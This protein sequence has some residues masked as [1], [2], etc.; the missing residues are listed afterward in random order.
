MKEIIL[1]DYQEEMKRR[2]E[3]AFVSH[4]S[5]M[6]Q[7][8]TGTGKTFLLASVVE[9]FLRNN[10]KASVWIV[11]HRRELVSQ[12]E[13]TL[14][15]FAPSFQDSRNS[16]S[17]RNSRN[18]AS[19]SSLPVKVCSIQWLTRHLEEMEGVGNAPGLIVIDEAHHAL[20]KTYKVLWERCPQAK[21]LGLTATPCRLNGRGFTDLFEVLVQSW[22]IPRFISEGRLATYDFVSIKASSKTQKLIDSLS[23]RGADGDYQT[24]EMDR[25]LNKRPSIERLFQSFS[26]YGKDRKGIVYAIDIDHAKAIA[27]FYRE[28]GISAVA[29]DSKTPCGLRKELIERFKLSSKTSSSNASSGFF[30]TTQSL[31]HKEG[32]TFSPSPSSSGSGD[33]TAPFNSLYDPFGSPCRGQKRRSEPLRSKVGGPSEVSPDFLTQQSCDCLCGVN[34]LACKEGRQDVQNIQV[35]VNVDIFSEGFD[36]PDV[37]FVQLARP[38]LSLAKYLQMVGRGLRVAHGKRNCV[39][40]DNVGLYRV[41]G[42]PSQVWNWEAMFA[43]RMSKRQLRETVS[44]TLLNAAVD[45]KDEAL[46]DVDDEMMM[47]VT[48]EQLAQTFEL[49][50]EDEWLRRKREKVLSGGMGIVNFIGKDL[51]KLTEKNNDRIAYVDLMNLNYIEGKNISQPKVVTEGGV[52]FLKYGRRLHSRTRRVITLDSIIDKGFYSYSVPDKHRCHCKAFKTGKS[53]WGGLAVVFLHD[54]PMDFYWLS[55]E[56]MDASIV[57]MGENGMYYWVENGKRKVCIGSGLSPEDECLLNRQVAEIIAVTQ[58]RAEEKHQERINRM[59]EVPI[60]PYQAGTKWGLRGGDGRVIVPP[61]YRKVREENGFFP[62]EQLVNHWGVMDRYGKILVKPEYDKV[63]ITEE[64]EAIVSSVTG[65]CL[66]I[67]L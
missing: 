16:S 4:Q 33:V 19:L 29:I 5:V 1:F 38:T 59:D 47:V 10:P 52:E 62:F 14:Q 15:R 39:V 50:K 27:E 37:E 31:L 7:M 34:R 46:R 41:F 56:M 61:I 60:S 45:K 65:K 63:V 25:L 64:G 12:I 18:S 28:Q 43:G 23:K 67:K 51:V 42:L 6:A 8:P 55:G 20:A 11:A 13:E 49:Q 57:V 32:S 35:L 48:H 26:E 17:Y 30:P 36:C 40:I 24:K 54:E 3:E 22:D 58:A 2:I 9:N 66:T 53:H 44:M 21:F